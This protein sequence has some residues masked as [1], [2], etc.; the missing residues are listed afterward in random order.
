MCDSKIVHSLK[1][2]FQILVLKQQE[3]SRV[4]EIR[5]E[6]ESCQQQNAALQKQV[7]FLQDEADSAF[8]AVENSNKTIVCELEEKLRREKQDR[9]ELRK[10]LLVSA[11]DRDEA[12]LKFSLLQSY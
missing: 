1:T 7:N 6:L 2:V 4:V 12:V 5:S 9:Q 3:S 11:A 8:R 10:Q